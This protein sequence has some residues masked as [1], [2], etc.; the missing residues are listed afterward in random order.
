MDE[1]VSDAVPVGVPV[2]PPNV[3]PRASF[4]DPGTVLV[5]FA[6]LADKRDENLISGESALL[7]LL[8]PLLAVLPVRLL[9]LL[10]VVPVADGSAFAADPLE[11]LL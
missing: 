10:L 1:D 8:V 7:L 5:P 4:P 3:M 6:S 2:D 11:G 9:L